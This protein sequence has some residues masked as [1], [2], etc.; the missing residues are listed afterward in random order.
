MTDIEGSFLAHYFADFLARR[1]PL[2]DAGRKSFMALVARLVQ[3]MEGGHSCLA[4]GPDDLA[5]L[6]PLMDSPVVSDKK[7]QRKTPLIVACQNLYLYRYDHYETR[8]AR[9]ITA[10]AAAQAAPPPGDLT[11]KLDELFGGNSGGGNYQRYAAQVASRKSLTI[12]SG[13]PGTGK[14]TTV[15]KILA[16]ILDV[17]KRRLKIALGAPTGKAA[18]RLSESV[19][20]SLDRLESVRKILENIPASASTLHR[21]LG[22]KRNSPRFVHNAANPM[23]WD[24]VV[25]DE[26]SMVDLAMM[27][28]LVDALKPGAKLILLG[29]KDQLASV[30]SGAVLADLITALPENSV[31][32]KTTYRFDRNIKRFAEMINRGDLGGCWQMAEDA[33]ITNLALLSGGAGSC[34]GKSYERY[35]HLA[36]KCDGE[37]EQ[38]IRRLFQAFNSFQVLCAVR[39]GGRG[40][41]AI[42]LSIEKWLA[43]KGYDCRPGGW[44]HGRPVLITRN[45][46]TLELY[47]GDVGICLKGADGRFRVW[48]ERFDSGLRSYSPNRLVQLQ[49]VYAMT[50]HKSQ[51]SEFTEVVV[52]LPE[53]DS[54]ILSR[55]L[56]YTAVTR[57]RE[58]VWIHSSREI[59]GCALG[60]T[61]VRQSG[62]CKR[63]DSGRT[64]G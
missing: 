22:V 25:V 12:I 2:E 13:G 37:D 33:Q 41:E 5:V 32:L 38:T 36:G 62:L 35:M 7:Q 3:A 54:R 30:E 26:A 56:V 43:A 10:L 52:V 21:M 58:Q 57:A 29:D 50:I 45:D 49:T 17:E 28:K 20:A 60:R 9:N 16:L 27:C 15:V 8:L 48:F 19:R 23:T 14:T 51:G 53:E 11:R 42:N 44:Y 40:E 4:L 6:E 63:I 39:Y 59:L 18:M 64:S 34:L 24:V 31:E 1:T 46:Y 55:E 47:N 61:A